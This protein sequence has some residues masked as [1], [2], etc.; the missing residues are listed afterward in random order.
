[1]P[2]LKGANQIQQNRDANVNWGKAR[3]PQSLHV[4]EKN[5]P[6]GKD[7][8]LLLSSI[9]WGDSGWLNMGKKN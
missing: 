2:A 9:M 7:T 4:G 6:T 1:M 3:R 8:S 5:L